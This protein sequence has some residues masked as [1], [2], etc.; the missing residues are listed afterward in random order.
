MVYP[1]EKTMTK[2]TKLK[3]QRIKNKEKQEVIVVWKF[4]NKEIYI[5]GTPK[6]AV[7][8]SNYHSWLLDRKRRYDILIDILEEQ[9]VDTKKLN[10]IIDDLF[11]KQDKANASDK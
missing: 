2:K 1:Q 5:A 8:F 4:Q 10:K 9:N 6:D 3:E 11:A 7:E